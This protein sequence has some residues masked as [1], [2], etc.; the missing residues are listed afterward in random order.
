MLNFITSTVHPLVGPR[1]A[2]I[3]LLLGFA[4][5]VG[6]AAMPVSAS[7]P[8]AWQVGCAYRAPSSGTL[9]VGQ[10]I[11]ADMCARLRY[12]QAQ[13]DQGAPRLALMGCFGFEPAERM[14]RPLR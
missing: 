14:A 13:A 3:A 9:G 8:A 10:V 12:C 5:L 11:L 7:E 6:S 2:G 4:A 1:R